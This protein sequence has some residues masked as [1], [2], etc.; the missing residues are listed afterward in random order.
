MALEE[1]KRKRRF[2]ETPEPPPKV[3][4]KKGNRFVVQKHEATRLHY[5]FRLEM[6]GV[7]KS[8]AVPKGPSLDPADK[9]LAMQVEDHPVSYFD[10]EGNIPEGNYG[11]GSVM[12]WD[13]GTWQPLSPTPVNGKYVPGTEA[14]AISMLAKG[15]L[16]FRLNGKRLKGDFALI[17][18]R[19]RR[20]GSKGNEWLMI[21]KHDD[22][23]VEGYD[24]GEIDESVLSKRSMDDI[25][26]DARSREWTSSRPA[27]RGKLKAAWLADAVRKLDQKKK[28]TNHNTEDAEDAEGKKELKTSPPKVTSVV[29]KP[30][31]SNGT[32]SLKSSASS[33]S[34]AVLISKPVKRPMPTSISPMLAE[35]I[36][37][38]FDSQ[39][40]LFEIKWDGYRAVA[41]IQNESVR[42]V[43]RNQNE[44]TARYPE[45]K[46]MAKAL[47]AKNAIID[48]EV[49]ALD[50]EGKPS[51]SLMQ[52]RTGFRPGGKRGAANADVPVLYYAFDLIYLD[53]E[54]WRKVPLE[55]RKRKLASIIKPGDSLRYSDHYE[56]QGQALFDLAKSTKLEG[57]VAKHRNSCYEERR[58]REWL[59][60]KIRHQ[61]ECVVGGFTEPE[62]SRA[63]FGSL[64]L[65]LY[66]DQKRLIHV[67]Q[68]GSGFNQKSLA[69][70]WKTL[71]KLETKKNPFY[72]EVEA[73]RKVAWVKPELTAEIEYSE[74]THGTGAGSGPKLRAPVFQ[75]LRDDKNPK[76]CTIEQIEGDHPH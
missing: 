64:V 48:G 24:A 7:L 38:P 75:G 17:K 39:E 16:K 30:A 27:G 42:L 36:E 43:S 62:G 50:S 65:G 67:G 32:K 5:D 68:A 41:F 72:G 52:Q 23:V 70:I 45:L 12:V 18:M 56:A 47:K 37:K 66:D 4:K 63:H 1:Y 14:E 22:H 61:I 10:F 15:D 8:W 51:F 40:W 29:A 9:R 20:P 55:E 2:E 26:G 28:K 13:V 53:G 33:A 59:K 76:E 11:A 46:D 49:V 71:Q 58:S 69:E 6:E 57:I 21:K 74:W 3:E 34:S 35:S 19:G 25:A 73:L 60:I 31:P 54:D 44:L